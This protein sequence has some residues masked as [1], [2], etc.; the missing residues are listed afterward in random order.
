[1]K[2][3]VIAGFLGSGKT[4]LLLEIARSLT[5]ESHKIVV[6]ENEVGEIGI[7]DQYLRHKGLQVQEIYGGCIC[8]TLSAN[9]FSTLQKVREVIQPDVTLIE[10][11]G[12]ANPGDLVS[13]LRD[14]LPWIQMIHLI[15]IV[16]A[17]RFEML[18]AMLLPMLTAQ[19]Q[20]ADVLVINKIDL[21]DEGTVEQIEEKV[22][23][24]N[25]QTRLLPL[26][27]RSGHNLAS[28]LETIP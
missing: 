17:T 21:V 4:T 26:S 14:G 3:V 23:Q 7:D 12:L 25:P 28:L 24:I 10:P 8:C 16:D 15:T 5:A 27:T 18:Q 9:L 6:I 11:T 13:S 20:T 22:R 19:I 1:M 2:L